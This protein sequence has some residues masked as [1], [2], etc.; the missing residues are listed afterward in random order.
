MRP[1]VVVV[2]GFALV[3][4]LAI[5]FVVPPLLQGGV[6]QQAAVEE[7]PV[8]VLVAA[9]ELPAG[10]VV[11]ESD[12]RW[13]IWPTD[14]IDPA[15]YR[16]DK[17]PNAA[18][19]LKGAAVRRAVSAGEPVTE[20]RLL[21]G[22][23]ANFLAGAL[24]PGTRAVSIQVDP[25]TGVAGFVL[26]GDRVDLILSSTFD[27]LPL[28]G[29]SP[30]LRTRNIGETVLT[31]LRVVAVEQTI[32]DVKGEPIKATSVTLEVTPAQ[33]E[34]VAVARAVGRLSLA[35]RSAARAPAE[36]PVPSGFTLDTDVSRFLATRLAEAEAAAVP[37]V[38]SAPAKVQVKLYKGATAQTVE[39]R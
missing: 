6:Q 7:A 20:V 23:K 26:P 8:A 32:N 38:E 3:L 28:P 5:F 36:A 18:G 4:A 30:P 21:R 2:V 34:K 17:A 25:V 11:E 16:S 22:G 19:E 29:A 10:K 37:R 9:V 13:Q 14:G 27:V 12:F 24:A 33:A 31:D 39:G 1:I 15:Y 35:L